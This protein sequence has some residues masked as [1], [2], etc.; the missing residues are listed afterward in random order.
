LSK[1]SPHRPGRANG[2][3]L[4]VRRPIYKSSVGRCKAFQAHLE[5]LRLS[6]GMPACHCHTDPEAA[7]CTHELEPVAIGTKRLKISVRAASLEPRAGNFL[8]IAMSSWIGKMFSSRKAN[9]RRRGPKPRHLL[10]YY[11][12]P[13]GARDASG[14]YC[15]QVHLRGTD[16]PL[17]RCPANTYFDDGA[18]KFSPLPVTVGERRRWAS[19]VISPC[20]GWGAASP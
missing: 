13:P 10:R 19:P 9:T 11:R 14:A 4:Q 15:Q 5:P 18:L 1:L 6:L 16:F 17:H 3:Q 12:L 8:E 7:H 20:S 2:Q